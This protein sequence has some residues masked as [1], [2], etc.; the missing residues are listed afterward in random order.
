V[1]VLFAA[2]N[3]R[4]NCDRMACS[5]NCAGKAG[6]GRARGK[7]LSLSVHLSEQVQGIRSGAKHCR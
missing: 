2:M 6:G 5:R 4:A 7:G 1:F 3:S